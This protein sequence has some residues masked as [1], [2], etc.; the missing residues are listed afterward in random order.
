[1]STMILPRFRKIND[2]IEKIYDICAK[3]KSFKIGKTH[4]VDERHN[5]PDYKE[6]YPN[7]E[8]LYSSKSKE[9]VSYMESIFIDA[10]L[11]DVP[12]L[13]DNTKNG[14]LSIN[15]TMADSEVYYVYIVW[16]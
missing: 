9:L 16:R 5:Q 3:C 7:V 10:C 13:C 11:E 4:D 2:A 14:E 12:D 15:D 1:M 8:I 6:K